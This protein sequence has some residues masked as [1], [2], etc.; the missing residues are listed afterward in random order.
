[1]TRFVERR[2][3]YPPDEVGRVELRIEN[4]QAEV[5]LWS[6]PGEHVVTA[7]FVTGLEGSPPIDPP[8]SVSF[9]SWSEVV[10][11]GSRFHALLRRFVG[12]GE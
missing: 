5:I 7:K 11:A 9:P 10:E 2:A 8:E 12:A 3:I 6:P 1:M 4:G